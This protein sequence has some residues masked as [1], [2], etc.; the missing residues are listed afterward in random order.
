MP[1]PQNCQIVNVKS[2]KCCYK[3]TI[4]T[5]AGNEDIG[6]VTFPDNPNAYDHHV[7]Q[8]D[9]VLVIYEF[10]GGSWPK[11]I[12]HQGNPNIIEVS[13]SAFADV[14]NPKV[15]E[16]IIWIGNN[17]SGRDA[18]YSI[19]TY[20]YGDTRLDVLKGQVYI[21][22]DG[23]PN[24]I[25][26]LIQA[27]GYSSTTTLYVDPISGSDTQDLELYLESTA[28]YQTITKAIA[29]MVYIP[30]SRIIITVENSTSVNPA[31]WIGGE[32][33]NKNISINNNNGTT[34][35]IDISGVPIFRGCML[36]ITGQA[37]LDFKDVSTFHL[38]NTSLYIQNNGCII[39]MPTT[40][41]TALFRLRN[42]NISIV[43][44]WSVNPDPTEIRFNSNDSVFAVSD[45]GTA[46]ISF[47]STNWISNSFTNCTVIGYNTV[48]GGNHVGNLANLSFVYANDLADTD[49][50]I[51]GPAV[52][53]VI[54]NYNPANINTENCIFVTSG[55]ELLPISQWN[56]KCLAT[57]P[58]YKVYK[59]F[60]TQTGTNA[61]VAT[62][63]ENTL[64][65]TP[66]W[67]YFGVG[68]YELTLAGAFTLN[69]CDVRL[70]CN[71]YAYNLFNPPV[72]VYFDN[73]ASINKIGFIIETVD[74]THTQVNDALINDFLEITVYP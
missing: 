22:K 4:E 7:V 61:P 60:L 57:K 54:T 26:D 40:A 45:G 27:S 10:F 5:V 35:Y 20:N 30:T 42:G 70:K 41:D 37:T 48:N 59:A 44:A 66:V 73:G 56:V 69:K 33:F 46:N 19:L 32:V 25:S 3:T 51:G 71:D 12:E 34:G 55:D 74:G 67:S 53:K 49:V 18:A 64:G 14:L 9:D 47:H 1:V 8:F 23:L 68:T 21:V 11:A 43:D 15:S 29:D 58:T 17:L 63:V 39:E 50:Y 24:K 72:N 36:E 52:V 65:G 2:D 38:I 13:S 28:R 31:I 6:N 62:V 16:L